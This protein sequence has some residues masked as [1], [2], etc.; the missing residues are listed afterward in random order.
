MRLLIMGPP[1]AGKGTQA[2]KIA[3][4][5][6][7]PAIS[8]GDILRG[9]VED[10]TLLGREAKRYLDAGELVP[11][12]II[13]GM[14]RGRLDEPDTKNGFLLDG[15]P[16]TLPQVGTLDDILADEGVALDRVLVLT[17]D[18]DELVKRVLNRANES[19]RSDDTEDVIRRRLQVYAD[20][21]EPLLDVYA[22][23]GVLV[24][25]NGMGEISEVTD[26]VLTALAE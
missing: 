19:G 2:K 9:N 1:G 13:N 16:R 17:A 12:E 6:S 3:D 7:I 5:L 4:R 20:Q 14:V 8:T 23:R 18:S 25:V 22:G 24:L 15:F 21:T 26:R 11:D 10:R